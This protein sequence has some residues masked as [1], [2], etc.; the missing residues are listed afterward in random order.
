MSTVALVLL[1]YRPDQ[2]SGIDRSIGALAKGLRELGHTPLVLTAGPAGPLDHLEPGL[3][4]LSSVTLPHPAT[5]ADVLAALADPAPVVAE[6]RSVL[7][8]HGAEA[9]CWGDTLWGLGYLS[10]A[11][12]EVT[13]ALM[14]HKIRPSEEQRWQNALAAADVVCPA[15][16]YL[17]DGGSAAGL[18]TS[19]WRPVLNALHTLITPPTADQRAKLRET[20]PVRIVSRADPAKGLAE[21]LWALP[22]DWNRPVELVLAEAGFELQTGGQARTLAACQEVAARRPGLVSILPALGWADVPDFFAGA[23]ATVISTQV[24]E[25][26]CF[27]AAEALS[28]GTPVVG[29]DLGNV[30]L[31]AGEAGRYAPLEAGPGALWR[32]VAEL[33]ADPDEYGRASATAPGR[34]TRFTPE[35]SARALLDAL[36][37]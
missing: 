8:E 33:L 37:L 16:D 29:V 17:A 12:A 24:P 11:P 20:G 22:S 32:A 13:T 18:D 6:V 10:P 15:S 3:V 5:N 19:R 14:V 36:G 23:A 35:K 31:L 4:R 7:A 21:L 2:P 26:F 34:I 27:T 9:V 30:P 1:S 28:A 25:T